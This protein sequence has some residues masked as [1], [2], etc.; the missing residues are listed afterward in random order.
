[1]C[2]WEGPQE[3]NNQ[4]PAVR[5]VCGRKELHI[6]NARLMT[7]CHVNELDPSPL[8]EKIG[9]EA[10]QAEPAR[11]DAIIEMLSRLVP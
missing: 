1:M 4:A 5:E 6:A 3:T 7:T 8:E 2:G 10:P 11:P 9:S